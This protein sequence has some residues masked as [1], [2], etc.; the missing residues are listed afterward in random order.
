MD[1]HA[2]HEDQVQAHLDRFEVELNE[3]R[4][5]ASR[6]PGDVKEALFQQIDV[7]EAQQRQVVVGFRAMIRESDE[8]WQKLQARNE[9][10][11]NDVAEGMKKA[12]ERLR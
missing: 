9:A 3:M 7:L 6:A 1:E 12:F 8:A 11:W 5:E 10:A 4:A 2:S